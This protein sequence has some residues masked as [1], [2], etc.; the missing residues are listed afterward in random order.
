[1]SSNLILPVSLAVIALLI[2]D[3]M[4]TV[5]DLSSENPGE[6]KL[7]FDEASIKSFEHRERYMHIMSRFAYCFVNVASKVFLFKET[8]Y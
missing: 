6:V 4:D 5:R 8:A 2:A 7:A 1:M 3:N